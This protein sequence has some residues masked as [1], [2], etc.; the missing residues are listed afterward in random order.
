MFFLRQA[1][2]AKLQQYRM[3]PIR[4]DIN[5]RNWAAGSLWEY[6]LRTRSRIM[7]HFTTLVIVVACLLISAQAAPGVTI[8][9]NAFPTITLTGNPPQSTIAYHPGFDQY[10]AS[11]TGYPTARA[12]V[13]NAS[14]ALLQT[15]YPLNIDARSWN[16]NPTTGNIEMIAYNPS[17]LFTM[18]LDG[19]GLLTG[20][21]VNT[22]PTMGS[23]AL[24]AYDANHNLFYSYFSGT[25][26]L[27]QS[28][29][30]TMLSPITLDLASAGSPTLNSTFA[31]Y[32]QVRNV[33]ITIDHTN[34]RALV[35]DLTGAYLGA[36]QLPIG[37]PNS[38]FAGYANG[39]LFIPD[40]IGGT[41]GFDIFTP[42]PATMSLLAIGGLALL[43]RRRKR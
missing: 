41:A 32:D 13:W 31:G 22:T 12:Y 35:H 25:T 2:S 38:Y 9:P 5:G 34:D 33:L 27:V 40:N 30:G 8:L 21:N 7:R 19:A 4:K 24:P 10:Y 36:S 28:S 17:G 29:I 3:V 20:V 37:T 43:R 1:T 18:G 14:G 11:Q 6:L 42:E 26:V 16:Y 23:G 39:Q 15:H